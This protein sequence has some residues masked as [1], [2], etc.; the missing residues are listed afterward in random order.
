MWRAVSRTLWKVAQLHVAAFAGL[1]M[2]FFIGAGAV[3]LLSLVSSAFY[4]DPELLILVLAFSATAG[5]LL[6]VLWGWKDLNGGSR[7][8]GRTIEEKG[9]VRRI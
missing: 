6:F 1:L 5:G 4:I 7:I 8:E 2:G 9:E 3:V